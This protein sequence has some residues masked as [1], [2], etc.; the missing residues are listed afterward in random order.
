MTAWMYVVTG[1]GLVSA[2]FLLV[3]SIRAG[4][5]TPAN[6]VWWIV[7]LVLLGIGTLA[8]IPLTVG[9]VINGGVDG[10]WVIPGSVAIGLTWWAAF[11]RPLWCSWL[12]IASAIVM[13][14]L[15]SLVPLLAGVS[16]SDN[17]PPP[18][19]FVTYGVPAL[20]SGLFL[21]LS[22]HRSPRMSVAERVSSA[23]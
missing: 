21:L 16:E 18:I 5:R 22:E 4:R 12:L 15:I 11:L 9:A 8:H 3:V 6:H 2:L 20:V 19:V 7:A 17:V 14:T 1:L 13:P 10:G 23:S